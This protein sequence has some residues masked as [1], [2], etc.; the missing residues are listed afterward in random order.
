MVFECLD[1]SEHWY[2]ENIGLVKSIKAFPNDGDFVQYTRELKTYGVS[3]STK[4][5]YKYF[6]LE[7]G[8]KWEYAI[9]DEN[10]IP[11]SKK[12]TYRDCYEIDTITDKYTFIANSGFIFEK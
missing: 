7:K 1:G 6:P 2:C 12:Y 8:N 11:Y 3:P 9:F 5:K 4:E 10:G